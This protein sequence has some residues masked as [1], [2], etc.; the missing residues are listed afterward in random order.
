MKNILMYVGVPAIIVVFHILMLPIIFTPT[1]FSLEQRVDL[2]DQINIALI[3]APLT[4]ASFVSILRFA[5][6][7]RFK[8]I[9]ELPQIGSHFFPILCIFVVLSF[10]ASIFYFLI[11][12]QLQGGR[13]IEL[14]KGLIGVIEIFFGAGYAIIVNSVFD[15]RN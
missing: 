14:L 15:A 11:T 8:K 12:F 13:D 7:N 2:S 5:S 4:S 1:L 9:S 3:V 6:D 10:F